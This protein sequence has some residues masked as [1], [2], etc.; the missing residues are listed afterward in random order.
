MANLL[1]NTEDFSHATWN[2]T[3]A[4]AIVTTNTHASPTGTTTADTI[5]D[6]NA[7]LQMNRAQDVSK[8][9]ND[10]TDWIASVYVRKDAITN[11]FPEFACQFRGG[12]TK[13]F[14][15]RLNTSTGAIA[16]SPSGAPDASGVIDVD[17][18]WWRV[19]WRAADNGLGNTSIRTAIYPALS[20]TTITAGSTAG[21]LG[22]M[23]CWGANLQH[24]TTIADYEPHPDPNIQALTG[25]VAT[26]SAGSVGAPIRLSGVLMTVSAGTLTAPSNEWV[27]VDTL[28]GASASYLDSTVV[29]GSAY[30]Y[31]VM[32][33]NEVG[34]TASNLDHET[35][36]AAGGAIWTQRERVHRGL[37]RGMH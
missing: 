5:E 37:F 24:A 15:I 27:T 6:N 21:A 30:E 26:M 35:A 18:N 3:A 31:R 22:S 23:I 17:A 14:A 33:V 4:Q 2:P 29:A 12:T 10:T 28:G 7:T 34:S 16:N 32:A 25:I 9:S 20:S 36:L 19:W 1:L 11:R 8:A 13:Y